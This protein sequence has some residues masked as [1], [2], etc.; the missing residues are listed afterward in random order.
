MHKLGGIKLAKM[1]YTVHTL[2]HVHGNAR[3]C[4][5]T[6]T[7]LKHTSIHSFTTILSTAIDLVGVNTALPEDLRTTQ[8][9]LSVL[10][11]L[12]ARGTQHA[13]F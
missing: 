8:K 11:L 9:R 13:C 4:T 10:F 6:Q 12:E 1:T 7:L 5:H 2:T 3:V